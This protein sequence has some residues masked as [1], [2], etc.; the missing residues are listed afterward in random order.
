MRYEDT[1]VSID[2]DDIT[3]KRYGPFGTPRTIRFEDIAEA[4]KS[5]L[6]SVA[7]WRLVGAGPGGGGRNW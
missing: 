5:R 1:T 3:I 4:T 7:S 6:G 2:S